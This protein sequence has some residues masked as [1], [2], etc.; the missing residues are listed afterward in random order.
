MV[1]IGSVFSLYMGSWGTLAGAER[2]RCKS[3]PFGAGAPGMTARAA[4]WLAN[5]KPKAF[6]GTPSFA[7]A[8]ASKKTMTVSP[9]A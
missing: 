2:L 1:F 3:F 9:S 5:F 8:S 4:M 6:Y 7:G